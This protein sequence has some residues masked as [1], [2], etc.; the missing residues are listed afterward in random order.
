MLCDITDQYIN[1]FFDEIQLKKENFKCVFWALEFG[2]PKWYTNLQKPFLKLYDTLITWHTWGHV[3]NL[4]K[5]YFKDQKTYS[6]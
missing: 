1:V 6:Q 3:D 4:K 2:C 5:F